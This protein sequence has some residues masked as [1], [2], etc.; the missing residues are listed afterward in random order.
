[1]LYQST[2]T[3][4]Q[5]TSY[6]KERLWRYTHPVLSYKGKEIMH[7]PAS[8]ESLYQTRAQTLYVSP[9]QYLTFKL[10]MTGLTCVSNEYLE[11]LFVSRFGIIVRYRDTIIMIKTI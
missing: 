10:G 3:R 5:N 6:F 11:K 8:P 2:P 4:E 1:M 9:V 7:R